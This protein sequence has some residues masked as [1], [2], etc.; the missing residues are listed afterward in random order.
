MLRGIGRGSGVADTGRQHGAR[1][2]LARSGC[3]VNALIRKRLLVRPDSNRR[4]HLPVR[5]RSVDSPGRLSGKSP[6][7]RLRYRNT[8][9]I[10]A[11]SFT[12]RSASDPLNAQRYNFSRRTTFRRWTAFSTDLVSLS[13]FLLPLYLPPLLRESVITARWYNGRAPRTSLAE[14][15]RIPR[16]A[17]KCAR[18]QS[19][20]DIYARPLSA[21]QFSL[22]LRFPARSPLPFSQFPLARSQRYR[23]SDAVPAGGQAC[24]RAIT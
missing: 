14:N 9:V 6:W 20:R 13:L 2:L 11:V 3:I 19:A 1:C 8:R 21:P 4:S 24:S 10:G 5:G 17:A 18:K 12:R 16:F 22:P 15:Q 23:S 7:E